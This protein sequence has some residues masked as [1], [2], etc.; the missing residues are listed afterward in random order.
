[1]RRFSVLFLLFFPCVPVWAAPQTVTAEARVLRDRVRIGDELRLLVQVD[2]P[3]KYEIAPPDA[4]LDV[5][6]FEIKRVEPAPVL[7]GQ[8]R[9]QRTFR[10]TLT[11]FQ[12]GDLK[13]PAIPVEYTD[14][15]GRAGRVFTE[16]VPVKVFSVGKKLTDKDDI[17]PIKGPVSTG[18]LRFWTGLGLLI[19]ALLSAVLTV[20]VFL[21]LR[22]A[23]RDLESRKPPHERVKIE[24]MRLK[25]HGYLEEKDYKA[26]YS[27]LSD[28]LRRY[29][30]RRLGVEALEKTSSELARELEGRSVDG[31]ALKGIREVLEQSDLIKFAKLTPSYELAAKLE[32]LLLDAV[33]RTKPVEGAKK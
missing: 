33:E 31:E 30:E 16:P 23:R 12:L 29:L 13:V 15:K 24:L 18:L 22:K 11:V 1:M 8:N 20:K 10:I 25:D 14:E 21:R 9:V 6:P 28:I 19:A 3:R 17:R 27:G 5:S 26:F 4:K 32:T 7:R 2:H